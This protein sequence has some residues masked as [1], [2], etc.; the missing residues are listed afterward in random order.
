MEF[1][2]TLC[3][4]ACGVAI[5]LLLGGVLLV[6]WIRRRV[7]QALG[8]LA[9]S[10]RAGAEAAAGGRPP[11][12]IHL[13]RRDALQWAR[14]IELDRLSDRLSELGFRHAGLYEI[15]ELPDFRLRAMLQPRDAVWAV[16]YEHPSLGMWVDVHAHYADGTSLTCSSARRGHE[17]SPRPGHDR[18]VEPG[19]EP[20]ELYRKCLARS[21]GKP[22]APAAAEDFPRLFERAYSEESAWREAG[23]AP[24]REQPRRITI[25]T[26]PATGGGSAR[27]GTDATDDSFTTPPP[28]AADD[29]APPAELCPQALRAEVLR[30]FR[31]QSEMD[32]QEWEQVRDRLVVVHERMS[33]EESLA[34][35]RRQAGPEADLELP[36]ETLGARLAFAWMNDRVP[37]PRRLRLVGVVDQPVRADVYA[38]VD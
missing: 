24:P 33:A 9:E 17:L 7:R 2:V 16:I 35:L 14:P 36:V 12:R 38:P 18:L 13:R 15:G 20:E 26:G 3:S 32:P 5:A 8:G 27:T 10:L 28:P 37:A 25:A 19:A 22:A 30:R 21:R 4:L 34:L 6:L 31:E 23:A 1:L 11:A 29:P